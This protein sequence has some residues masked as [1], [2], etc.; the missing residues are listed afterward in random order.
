MTT[1]MPPIKQMHL[2]VAAVIERNGSFL[3]VTDDTSQGYKL[4]Q[5]AGHVEDGED[6]LS[7]VVREVKEEAG[8]NFYP[9]KIIGIYLYKLNSDHTYLR[10]CFKGGIDGNIEEPKPSAM[11]DGVID[12]KWYSKEE[13]NDLTKYFR[14]H[15][16]KQ[17]IDDYLAGNEYDLSILSPYK[18]CSIS[19]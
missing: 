15:L 19:G 7:A 4:N 13:L 11:D 12:A 8:I 10:I 9:E 5:P 16:V 14:S 18:D 17:C 6:I 1:T 2:T 3:M